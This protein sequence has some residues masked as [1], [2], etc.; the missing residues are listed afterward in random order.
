MLEAL[1]PG[2][3]KVDV[4]DGDFLIKTDQS[5]DNGGEGSAPEPFALFLASL[6]ACAGI[7]AKVF[8]DARSL[9]SDGLKVTQETTVNKERKMLETITLT[10][11]VGADFPEKYEGS[12]LKSMNSCTVKRH[13]HPDI[14]IESKLIRSQ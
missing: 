12:I 10:L 9:N 5:Q 6:T 13:L 3:K 11:S 7:Y 8:C 14:R 2:G 1:F 4:K